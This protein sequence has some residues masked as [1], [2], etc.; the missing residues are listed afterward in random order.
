M[1]VKIR[2]FVKAV[3]WVLGYQKSTARRVCGLGVFEACSGGMRT[4]PISPSTYCPRKY[5]SGHFPI[6]DN[7]PSFLHGVE[8]FLPPPSA[9]LQYKAIYR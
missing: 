8:H 9:D 5:Y 4:F 7:F 1:T 6:P 3:Q 2:E